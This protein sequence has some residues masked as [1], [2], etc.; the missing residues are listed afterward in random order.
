LP[1]FVVAIVAD[2][3]RYVGYVAVVGM[4]Y[5]DLK[6]YPQPDKRK[7]EVFPD[8]LGTSHAAK[9]VPTDRKRPAAAGPL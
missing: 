6:P 8:R 7:R 5:S 2:S 9:P 4:H 1:I 3:S